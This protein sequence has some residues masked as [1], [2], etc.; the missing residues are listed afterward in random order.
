MITLEQAK[1]LKYGQELYFTQMYKVIN[2][3][4]DPQ[5][6]KTF[7]VTEPVPGEKVRKFRVSGKPKTWKT[8]PGDVKVPIKYGLYE[9]AYVGTV[10][11][12][13]PLDRFFLDYN[14]AE[15]TLS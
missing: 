4:F 15:N 10:D 9:N 1:N 8:R 14:E 12:C 7:T 2:T 3:R 11:G 5:T 13:E 6:G